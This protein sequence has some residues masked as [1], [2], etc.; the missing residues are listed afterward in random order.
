MKFIKHIILPLFLCFCQCI[1]AQNVI[2]EVNFD[3]SFGKD[4]NSLI[5]KNIDISY[6]NDRVSL[7]EVSAQ[8]I[9]VGEDLKAV[10]RI[11]LDGEKE[12]IVK[13]G[14]REFHFLGVPGNSY[15]IKVLPYDDS[16]YNFSLKEVL[17]VEFSMEKN[18]NI[19]FPV[20]DVDT[21]LNNFIADNYR[22]L[23][24]KDS[25][26]ISNLNKLEKSLT[27][28]YASNQYMATYVNYEFASL[29]YGL[30][31]GSQKKVREELFA[32][33]PI[34]YDN[35]GYMDCFNTVFSHYFSQGYKF[36]DRNDIEKYLDANNYNGFND[37][38]GRDPVLVNE[39]FREL[40]FLQGMKDAYLEGVFD[41]ERILKMIEKFV[42]ITKFDKH[43]QIAKNLLDYLPT[44][45]FFG[46]K[47]KELM[48]KDIDGNKVSINKFMDKPLVVGL[49]QLDCTSCLK[50]LETIHYFY[51]SI[52]DNCNIVIISMDNSFEKMYNFVKNSKAGSKYKFPFVHFDFNWD[53]VEQY[54][55]HF[56][57][58]FVLINPDGTIKRNPFDNPSSGS[59]KQFSDKNK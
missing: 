23:L 50:E 17:P 3:K 2:I 58:K 25:A 54:H 11:T 31:I 52:K 45:D 44:R 53:I 19:N 24:I 5:N 1:I 30:T 36:I 57:P 37:A 46:K 56:L 40:V 6:I 9:A 32:S 38:L 20:E 18:D 26:T 39:V 51:D 8:R 21:M 59:L 13:V 4:A 42:S 29:K 10:G 12:T 47:T 41:R 48:V 43:K 35:I 34:L 16:A 28:K 14:L 7:Q 15:T 22:M 33:S 55:L 49:I 27:D